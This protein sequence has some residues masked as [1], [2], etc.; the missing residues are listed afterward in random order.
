MK[1]LLLIAAVVFLVIVLVIGV[2]LLV[3]RVHHNHTETEPAAVIET[4]EPTT[5]HFLFDDPVLGEI[6]VP[7]LEGVAHCSY[8]RD[9]YVEKDG[10]RYYTE[11]GEIT[12]TIGID[13]SSHQE[14]IDWEQVKA[15]GIDFAFIRCGYRTYETGSLFED[16]YFRQ[17]IEGAQAAGL[18]V[19]L[20]F[21]SQAIT[22]AE[23]RKEAEKAIELAKDYTFTYPIAYDWETV[24][25]DDAR[26]D[27]MT[28]ERLTACTLAFCNTI[29]DAGYTPVI[30][31]NAE[32]ALNLLDLTKL[33]EYDLWLAEH[34]DASGYYYDYRIWQYCSDG[35]VPGITGDV[36]LNI[37]YTPYH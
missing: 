11:D 8:D 25:T 36:D 28:K 32:T 24:E 12:S 10:W 4:E 16:E 30:Y 23:A 27:G 19:G 13:V 29:R 1:I 7:D 37:C 18:E 33:T 14:E 2:L 31:Q 35:T 6:W 15:A 17:N 21:Y 5:P 26:T 22:A 20:Y 9:N 34:R 3:L